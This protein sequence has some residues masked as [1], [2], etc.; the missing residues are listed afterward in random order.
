[1]KH[2]ERILAWITLCGLAVIALTI[3][4]PARSLAE[5]GT[6]SSTI[7]KPAAVS[8]PAFDKRLAAYLRKRF[9]LPDP[10]QVE[11][12]PMGRSTIA[13]MF[14]RDVHLTND[15]GQSGKA[16]VFSDA[17][18]KRVIIGNLYDLSTVQAHHT[19]D[20]RLREFL[21]QKFHLPL[22]KD[23]EIGPA[24]QSSIPGVSVREVNLTNERGQSAKTKVFSDA[25]GK[26][27]ILGQLLDITK[28]PWERADLSKAHLA[29]RPVLGAADA[30]VTVVEFADFE[31]PYCAHAFSVLETM[32]NT[33]YKGK[34]RLI[35]KNF[36]LNSHPWAIRAAVAADCARLQ[37]PKAFWSFAREFYTKQGT[38]TPANLQSRVDETAKRLGLDTT[39]LN[40]CMKNRASLER[41]AQDEAD[42]R[43]LSVTSTPTFFVNGVRVIGLPDAKAFDFVM[44]SQIEE[45]SNSARK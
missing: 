18:G 38:I 35:F 13:G 1:M 15:T 32:V 40:V 27:M 42:G 24:K 37:N 34:I 25:A 23:V 21:Q 26:Q 5:T 2:P 14:V 44:K 11:L 45:A 36:P 29:D 4:L 19:F 41:V 10:K 28:D 22:A 39:L 43:A 8:N 16:E 20:G 9:F 30:P 7:S 12:G 3:G 6:P 17:A 33:T 31:C